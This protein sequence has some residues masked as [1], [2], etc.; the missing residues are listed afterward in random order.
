ML[1]HRRCQVTAVP[2]SPRA[3]AAEQLGKRSAQL[4]HWW[5]S[6]RI[7]A[8]HAGGPGS[9]PGQCSSLNLFDSFPKSSSNSSL[10]RRILVLNQDTFRQLGSRFYCLVNSTSADAEL[11]L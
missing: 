10:L 7:L 11:T 6:G 3:S 2:T 5:F 9:I 8:C 1:D 4:E